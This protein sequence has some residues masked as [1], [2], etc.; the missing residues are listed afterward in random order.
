MCNPSQE[1]DNYAQGYPAG[2]TNLRR[3]NMKTLLPT[4]QT[5]GPFQ[6]HQI[7]QKGIGF[8]KLTLSK[9]IKKILS[10]L[11]DLNLI[12]R[13]EISLTLENSIE[14]HGK[15]FKMLFQWE[16]GKHFGMN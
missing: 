1:G 12:K 7:L 5:L 2:K 9:Q 16:N 8:E 3:E 4:K 14:I 10:R 11:Y 13:K 15:I 6:D